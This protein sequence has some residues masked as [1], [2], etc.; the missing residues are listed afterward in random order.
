MD[1]KQLFGMGSNEEKTV[2]RDW[3]L[4][5]DTARFGPIGLGSSVEDVVAALGTPDDFEGDDASE[6]AGEEFFS[7]EHIDL[8]LEFD[9]GQLG[10]INFSWYEVEEESQDNA[11]ASAPLSSDSNPFT[12]STADGASSTSMAA[13]SAGPFVRLPNGQQCALRE[14]RLSHLTEALGAPSDVDSDKLE[15]CTSEDGCTLFWNHASHVIHADVYDGDKI[16][17]ISVFYEEDEDES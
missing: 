12:S 17:T 15:Q 6:L 5:L 10:D 1:W 11:A 8:S 9:E 13:S 3:V 16:D 2:G 14:L 7:Y 4:D